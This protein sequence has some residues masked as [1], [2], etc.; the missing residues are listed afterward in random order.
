MPA[1]VISVSSFAEI[2]KNVELSD[3]VRALTLAAVKKI[4][5]YDDLPLDQKNRLYDMIRNTYMEVL[6]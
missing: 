2:R 5:G 6:S 4:E 3:K 1:R